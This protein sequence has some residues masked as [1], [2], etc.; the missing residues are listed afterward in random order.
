MFLRMSTILVFLLFSFL[1]GIGVSFAAEDADQEAAAPSM[2]EENKETA[3]APAETPAAG[4]SQAPS[5][6]ETK[7]P[8]PTIWDQFPPDVQVFMWGQQFRIQVTVNPEMPKEKVGGV[9]AIKL[10]KTDGTFLGYRPF[11]AEEPRQAIFMTDPAK[12]EVKEAKV[13]ITSETDGEWSQVIS[14]EN[15]ASQAKPIAAPAPAVKQDPSKTQE[16]SK[17]KGWLW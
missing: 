3:A 7:A 12:I 6:K 13:T 1:F 14:L 9:S 2:M 8:E 17:K 5:E 4:D 15:P 10:E 16:K 11:N